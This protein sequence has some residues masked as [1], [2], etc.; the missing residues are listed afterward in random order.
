MIMYAIVDTG[1][2]GLNNFI[3]STVIAFYIF[4]VFMIMYLS[5]NYDPALIREL[6]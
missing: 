3:I 1:D 6:G 5:I 4:L 2:L